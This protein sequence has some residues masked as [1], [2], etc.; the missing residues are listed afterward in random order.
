MSS[1][2]QNVEIDIWLSTEI[3]SVYKVDTQAAQNILK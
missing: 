3:F 1:V 2:Y